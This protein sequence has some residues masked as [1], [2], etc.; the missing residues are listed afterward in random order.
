KLSIAKRGKNKKF[1]SNTIT[2]TL[3]QAQH[4]NNYRN[5]QQP[6]TVLKNIILTQYVHRK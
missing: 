5:N 1:P 3:T 2:P 6:T 4:F